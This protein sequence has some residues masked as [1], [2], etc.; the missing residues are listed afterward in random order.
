MEKIFLT[1]VT[2]FA[3]SHLAERL[4]SQGYKLKVLI[5]AHHDIKNWQHKG[6]Q[7]VVG[8]LAEDNWIDETLE[9]VDAVINIAAV[10]RQA[11]I[12]DSRYWEVN[13]QGTKNLALA[14]LRHRIKK[15]IH[16]STVGVLGHIS[17][18]PADETAP[19]NPGDIYQVTKC[20]AEKLVLKYHRE[21]N[22]PLVVIRPAA[23]Y[24]PGDRRLLKIFSW[25]ARRRFVMLGDGKT[26]YHMV[27]VDDLANGFQLAL[28]KEEAVGEIFIIAGEETVSLNK[29]MEMI[30][31]ELKVPP[32]RLHFPYA[33]VYALAYLVEKIC[34]PLR[35]EP[36]IYRR[37][38][39]FFI[40]DRA[41]KIDKARSLLG[42]QPKYSLE[43][44]IHLT[45]QWYRD[46][47]WL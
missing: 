28:E 41:F 8:D 10:Y 11:G 4:Q 39:E 47:G 37:R 31:E 43:K 34:I 23:I 45:A 24:G 19:Y 21:K 27:Y 33:P 5:R 6:Y 1:G 3:G 46:K 13:Y 44:G 26:L 42:Y 14:S 29:L 40:K 12:P 7:V 25:T 22:L 15:F 38:I 35:I 30:A 16:C 2:G 20:E 17:N 36:P 18:P 32:P 9:D